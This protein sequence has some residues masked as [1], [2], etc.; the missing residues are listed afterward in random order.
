MRQRC[1]YWCVRTISRLTRFLP[2]LLEK[3]D[4]AVQEPA[5]KISHPQTGAVIRVPPYDNFSL[6]FE[7]QGTRQLPISSHC[8]E[9]DKNG[10]CYRL[11]ELSLAVEVVGPGTH[12]FEL[13]DWLT[14]EAVHSITVDFHECQGCTRGYETKRGLTAPLPETASILSRLPRFKR[15]LARRGRPLG[16]SHHDIPFRCSSAH[17]SAW[18]LRFVRSHR[19]WIAWINVGARG[20]T[21]RAL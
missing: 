18:I 19:D 8:V 6:T 17:N 4:I 9:I 2:R 3:D 7:N 1:L 12:V 13:K 14:R 11:F 15:Q 20:I 21:A 16:T 10:Q 5:F